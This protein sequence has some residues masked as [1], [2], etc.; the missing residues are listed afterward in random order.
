MFQPDRL[1]WS[2]PHCYTMYQLLDSVTVR[3][4]HDVKIKIA[5]SV[6]AI[7]LEEEECPMG[8]QSEAVVHM[9][10]WSEPLTLV[11]H[12]YVQMTWGT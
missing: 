12:K 4:I 3:T 5:C 8:E 9:E 11:G 2:E 7:L 1:D 10:Q 6:E